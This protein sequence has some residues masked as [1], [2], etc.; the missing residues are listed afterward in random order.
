MHPQKMA[1]P[2]QSVGTCVFITALICRRW[3]LGSQWLILKHNIEEKELTTLTFHAFPE[4][5]FSCPS[6]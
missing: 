4:T 2:P 1:L 5:L 6:L 3:L